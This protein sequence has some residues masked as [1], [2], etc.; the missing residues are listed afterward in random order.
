MESFFEAGLR[1]K[2]EQMGL[3]HIPFWYYV[4]FRWK[5]PIEP[6]NATVK[7]F[8]LL[9]KQVTEF[10]ASKIEDQKTIDIENNHRFFMLI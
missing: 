1:K 4:S 6:Q 9:G 7:V 8:D 3:F 10:S 2:Y 5:L